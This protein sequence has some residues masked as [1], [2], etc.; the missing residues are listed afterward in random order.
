ME[1]K[2]NIDGLRLNAQK[3]RKDTFEKIDKGIQ[4]LIK[5]GGK[6]NFNTVAQTAGVSKAFLYKEPDVK[7][8]IE[9][10]RAK[11]TGKK[12]KPKQSASDASKDA[13]IRT[14]KERIKKLNSELQDLRK[15]NQVA[16]GQVMQLGGMREKLAKC[17]A[18]NERLRS[19]LNEPHRSNVSVLPLNEI[20]AEISGLGVPLNSTLKRLIDD[21]PPE[22]TR[23]ALDALKEA[24]AGHRVENPAGFLNKAMRDAW[25][26]NE[27]FASKVEADQ[28][29]QW[30]PLA[31]DAGLVVGATMV[32]NVQHVFT[33][34]GKWV[35]FAEMTQKFPLSSITKA[36]SV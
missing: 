6:I 5:E 34:E 35:P 18:E 28:F 10:L 22:A 29:N 20:E 23:R 15:Q 4:Q 21:A 9:E 27:G 31:R 2:R 30:Y 8:R 12:L 19:R 13:M 25:Q 16:Y 26:P 32:E 17:E 24:M 14:L 11:Q 33:P 3:K 1:H 7:A 36:R